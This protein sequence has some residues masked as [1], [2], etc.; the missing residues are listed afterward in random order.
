M[1]QRSHAQLYPHFSPPGLIVAVTVI[2]PIIQKIKAATGA[3][4]KKCKIDDETQKKV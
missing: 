4:K 2:D 3:G 1:C